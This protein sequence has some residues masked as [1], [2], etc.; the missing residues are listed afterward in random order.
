MLGEQDRHREQ[1]QQ[2][3][4]LVDLVAAEEECPRAGREAE[5]YQ[6]FSGAQEEDDAGW[7][8]G[9]QGSDES[10]TLDRG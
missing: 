10:E 2:D 5:W 3:V 7:E 8:R 1:R 4:L 9:E 6:L